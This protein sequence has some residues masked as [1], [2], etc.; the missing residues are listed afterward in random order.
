[1]ALTVGALVAMFVIVR[2]SSDSSRVSPTWS[3]DFVWARASVLF[4][5]AAVPAAV[6]FQLSYTFHAELV[7]KRA[8]SQLTSDLNT[9]A[10]RI[11]QQAQ[12]V[13]VCTESDPGSQACPEI[14]SF[15]AQRTRGTLWDVDVPRVHRGQAKSA[16]DAGS[17]PGALRSFLRLA[18][19]PITTSP[20]IC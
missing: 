20:P 12:R 10:R 13:A 7:A 2:G 19:R 15:V 14:G 9:R 11:N 8:E 6:C 17:V 1:M 3:T 5:L 4:L 16:D 18:Y